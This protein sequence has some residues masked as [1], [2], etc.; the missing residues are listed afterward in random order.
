MHGYSMTTVLAI[1]ARWEVGG[2]RYYKAA[3]NVTSPQHCLTFRMLSRKHGVCL[4]WNRAKAVDSTRQ[5]M[6]YCHYA[7]I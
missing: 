4:V 6:S 2:D 5:D 3:L 7:V 1:C